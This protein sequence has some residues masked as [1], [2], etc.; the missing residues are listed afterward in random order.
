VALPAFPS[1]GAAIEEA[2]GGLAPLGDAVRRVLED[3]SHRLVAERVAAE[4]DALPSAEDAIGVLVAFACHHPGWCSAA[5]P[6]N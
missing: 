6:Y 3:P 5:D 4:T 2:P 1:T